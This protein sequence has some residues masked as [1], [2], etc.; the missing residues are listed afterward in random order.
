MLHPPGEE[1]KDE[2]LLVLRNPCTFPVEV[3]SV[4]LDKEL[5]KEEKVKC[6][7]RSQTHSRKVSN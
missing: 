5:V 3:Y 1:L 2:K 4:E 6:M 7:K